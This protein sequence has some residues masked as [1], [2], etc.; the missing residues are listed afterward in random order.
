M[1]IKKSSGYM[2]SYIIILRCAHKFINRRSAVLIDIA[3]FENRKIWLNGLSIEILSEDA[4]NDGTNALE[5]EVKWDNY[6]V[7][8]A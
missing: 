4:F 2:K 8:N 6:E 5:I 3:P 7:E 1:K